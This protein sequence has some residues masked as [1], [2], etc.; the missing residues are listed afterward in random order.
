MKKVIVI[1]T[2]FVLVA[3]YSLTSYAHSGGTDASGGHHNRKTGGYHYHHGMGPHQHPNG[4]C[5]YAQPAKSYP[6]TATPATTLKEQV[7]PI[8]ITENHW[9]V[10]LNNK[11]FKGKLE[12]PVSTGRVDILTDT[13]VI[14]VD[15]VSKYKGGIEQ[16]LR[17]AN[18]TGK[19][20]VLALY[21]DGEKNGYELFQ[22]A[23]NLCKEKEVSL[24]L[25]N[26][27]VSVNDLIALV[28]LPK[29]NSSESENQL[30]CWYNAVSGV[31]HNSSCRYYMNTKY[32]RK[33]SKSEGRACGICGG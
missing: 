27:Y 24:L 9:Q 7:K 30:N 32:G 1:L 3:S 25:I 20:P 4:V 18:A 17:Y 29:S 14:E 22:E 12:V 23:D 28:L 11:L 10:A 33:C 16:A 31:R 19:K 5:P 13:F 2:L 26:S 6:K 8:R 21:I 15:K